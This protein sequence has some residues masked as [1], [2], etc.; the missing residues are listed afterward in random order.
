VRVLG[1]DVGERRI[2]VACGDLATGDVR[3]LTTIHRV[4]PTADATLL[5]RLADEQGATE[6]VVGLPLRADGSEGTQ[7]GLTRAWADGVAPLLGLPIAWRDERHS[8][9]NAEARI[10]NDARRGRSGG[11]PSV[12]A[13]RA[14]RARVD[15]EA[16][17][18]IVQSE[19]DARA[20]GAMTGGATA[21]TEIVA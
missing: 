12:A 3:A 13:R 1:V 5:R 2:G 7:A 14:H 11:A 20:A 4:D 9:Q 16:A 8:S 19:L 21:S 10:G 17:A 18:S 6:L 15:R